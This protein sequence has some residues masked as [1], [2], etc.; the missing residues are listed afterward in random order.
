M[1]E[2]SGIGRASAVV[3]AREG[4]RVVVTDISVEGGQETL[5]VIR[6]NGGEAIF[7][8]ADVTN[9]EDIEGMV[10]VPRSIEGNKI[11]LLFRQ[12]TTGGIKISFRS[13]GPV[14]V[15][16]LARQFGGGGH[17]KASG[18]MVD[19]P[20]ERAIREVLRAARKMIARDLSEVLEE[21]G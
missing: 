15:N 9:A 7:V 13:S 3:L 20:L 17:I 8:R 10:D 12:A 5:E 6:S 11:A 16:E 1:S 21:D 18:A 4:A 14:N 19:G 2:G